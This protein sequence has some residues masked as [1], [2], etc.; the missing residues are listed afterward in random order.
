MVGKTFEVL[1]TSLAQEQRKVIY[2]FELNL[3]GPAYARKVQEAIG[4][5]SIVI[6]T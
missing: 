1:F 4:E 6:T 3:N 2:Y 5:S